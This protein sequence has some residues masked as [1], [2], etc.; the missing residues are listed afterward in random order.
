MAYDIFISYRR[1]TGADDARLL[2]QALKARGYNVFFD[3]D[4]LR[5]GKFDENILKAIDE[6]SIFVLM[7]TKES[8]DRCSIDGDWVKCEIEHALAGKKKIVPV[9][10]ID[11][12]WE[13]PSILPESLCCVKTEQISDMVK[14]SLFEE[15]ID[16][17]VEDRFPDQLK[18]KCRSKETIFSTVSSASP[19]FVG[20]EEEMGKLHEMLVAGKF[21]IITGPGG[22]GK[23]ELARQYAKSYQN[24]YPGGLFQ[25]DME[26]VDNWSNALT[27]KLLSPTST[28]EV[29]V[30]KTLS[31]EKKTSADRPD[32]TTVIEALNQRADQF[33]N[34]LLLLD[35]VDNVRLL[36]REQILEK[37]KFHS[38][39]RLLVTVRVSD[40]TFRPVDHCIEFPLTDI[41]PE[42]AID[43]LLRDHPVNSNEE[44][45]AAQDIANSL[46]YRVLYLRAIPALLDDIYSPYC[47]SFV[48]LR[49]S[50]KEN[51]L[52]TI[53]AGMED[54]GDER[55]T[56]GMIWKMTSQ[57]LA[58]HPN[59]SKW[60]KLTH[61]ASFFSPKG[62]P[63]HLLH[64][65]WL[66]LIETT[67][68]SG[69]EIS[70]A[71]TLT[72]LARHGLLEVHDN[73][74]SMHRLT[75]EA[76]K[77]SAFMEDPRIEESI[78][79]SLAKSM[80][81]D[82]EWLYLSDSVKI[83][84]QI[85]ERYFTGMLFCHLLAANKDYQNYCSWENLSGY[86]WSSLLSDQPW[87]ADKCPW[88]KLKGYDWA[89]LLSK[90]PQFAKFC[91]W[92]SFCFLDW[93]TLL[94]EQPQFADSCRW[95]KYGE[96]RNWVS[97]LLKQPQFAV[98]CTWN[99]MDGSDWARLLSE[100]P[101]F[102]DKCQWEKLQSFYWRILLESQPQFADKC[103][104]E[105]LDDID[106]GWLS[107]LEKQPQFADKC[108]WEKLKENDTWNWLSLL[109]EQPQFADKCPWE[110]L[111][112]NDTWNWLY[113]LA[114]QP[115]FADKC[116]WEKLKE[117]DTW[118]WLYLLA[119]QPQ[120]AD[121]CPW[122]KLNGSDWA[123]LLI[124]QPQFADK[125]SWEKLNNS[126]WNTL[127]EKQPQ[128][129]DKHPLKK[130]ND[131]EWAKSF[132]EQLRNKWKDFEGTDWASLL[133]EQPQFALY[134]SWE[135]LDD[136]DWKK[137]LLCQPQFSVYRKQ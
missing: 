86:K 120:F 19:V 94:V 11:L 54:A 125:C 74:L 31:I 80:I 112:E 17:I 16:R 23:S 129:A 10:Q 72:I 113:L 65:L 128:F 115:Q 127:I 83:L 14:T 34:V 124:V 55:R 107:L 135:K 35:N 68:E 45:V 67:A 76:V 105:N 132:S 7:L 98:H 24:E 66:S 102:A 25:L 126:D 75:R 104:W 50:L 97:L 81:N 121:K 62:F 38:N 42:V 57:A 20:R 109:E 101:Q 22:T 36:L 13:W 9:K 117:N 4:S 21:P 48:Q 44:I 123:S 5:D 88:E 69:G 18:K 79:R 61:I 96:G 15:S 95:A 133:V 116:P 56:P 3:Y 100:Q 51:F 77:E 30:Y 33:G 106:F 70:F 63:P 43:L 8:L 87:F 1:A 2:Q 27:E 118:K 82:Y 73:M 110:K 49:D 131:N 58:S 91:P 89:L 37:L 92:E 52:K 26:G 39:I 134:C 12:V 53:G 114:K 85:P 71:Q 59:G 60:I 28:P 47:G 93:V 40:I 122:E 130:I 119:K 78:G 99:S 111:K 32:I 64:Y 84:Q 108:P 103:P 29:K 46:G 6:A 90:Q 41:S 136:L 137:L